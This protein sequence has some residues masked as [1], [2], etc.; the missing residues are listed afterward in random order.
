M[1][2]IEL[3]VID[4]RNDE[5][6]EEFEV[7]NDSDGFAEVFCGICGEKMYSESCSSGHISIRII[8]EDMDEKINDASSIAASE[9]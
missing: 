8:D 4:T 5:Y 3:R 1:T 2:T 6:L 7:L 9:E